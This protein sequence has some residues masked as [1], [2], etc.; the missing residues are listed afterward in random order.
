[1][2]L[3]FNPTTGQLDIDTNSGAGPGG[4]LTTPVEV[5]DSGSV[6]DPDDR[7][8]GWLIW[9]SDEAILKILDFINGNYV[10]REV[11]GASGSNKYGSAKYGSAKYA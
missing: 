3:K 7:I 1:M 4:G 10:W 5:V 6:P 9:I 11:G 8:L 2:G